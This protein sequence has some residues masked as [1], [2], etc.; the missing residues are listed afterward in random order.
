MNRLTSRVLTG[1]VLTLSFVTAEAQ[2]TTYFYTGSTFTAVSGVYGP[3][4]RITGSFT[5]PAPLGPNLIVDLRESL[6][7]CS[8]SDGHQIRTCENSDFGSFAVWTDGDGKIRLWD[9]RLSDRP[10]ATADGE[11]NDVIVTWGTENQDGQQ[12]I[13]DIGAFDTPCTFRPGNTCYA[14]GGSE[15]FGQ[16][17]TEGIPP[18][19]WTSST[20]GPDR[21]FPTAVQGLGSATEVFFFA[22]STPGDAA[23]FLQEDATPAQQ[24][25]VVNFFSSDGQL[26]DRKVGSVTGGQTRSFLFADPGN[27][28][29]GHIEFVA[30]SNVMASA[31]I[32]LDIPG[33]GS[34]PPIGVVPSEGCTRP[35]AL[36]LRDE[37][38]DTGMALANREGI[39][40]QCNFKIFEGE[41][42]NLEREGALTLGPFSQTQEFPLGELPHGR[43][44]IQFACEAPVHAFSLFQKRSSGEVFSNTAHCKAPH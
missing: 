6:I 38:F 16:A 37:E 32:R 9:I 2:T 29:V 24:P 36:L 19:I 26:V 40:V 39:A 1:A 7:A 18:L 12:G 20:A 43:Y 14:W 27:L 21:V 31:I 30:P 10:I 5:V 41:E 34:L 44:N 4:D 11:I 23:I 13:S 3:S 17:L 28:R 15:N 33:V 25:V 35:A 8:F 22:D 42:G